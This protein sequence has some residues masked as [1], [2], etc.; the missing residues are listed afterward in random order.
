MT[1]TAVSIIIPTYNRAPT[2][3]RAVASALQ[4]CAEHDEV[5]VIDDGSTDDTEQVLEPFMERIR[6]H[7]V[8]NGGVGYARNIGLNT[9]KNEFIAF[10]DSDDEWLPGKLALQRTLLDAKP[11]LAFCFS[12][13]VEMHPDGKARRAIAHEGL[14]ERLI[15]PGVPL[16]TLIDAPHE[17]ENISVH[18]GDLYLT[19][20]NTICVQVN[21]TLSRRT[22][23]ADDIRFAEDL[24]YH[25]DWEFFSRLARKGPVAYLDF[26]TAIQH[27]HHLPQLTDA[28]LIHVLNQRLNVLDRVWGE[29]G[30][31]L[32]IHREAFQKRKKEVQYG[33]LEALA[34]W[35]GNVQGDEKNN[36]KY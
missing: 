24:S 20:L 27:Y 26:E 30:E 7:R 35:P 1:K 21:T 33:L 34:S 5:I 15:G 29:D 23:L 12:G 8:Q 14:G 3:L 22:F 2:I 36:S 25:E 31:F 28:T 32:K 4:Q 19:Q 18:I 9:A 6:Y 10:L 17:W 13:L 11:E 16:S